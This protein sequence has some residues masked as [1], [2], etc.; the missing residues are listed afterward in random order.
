MSRYRA[1]VLGGDNQALLIVQM[2]PLILAIIPLFIFFRNLNM[3]N[4]FIPVIMVYT[5]T[6]LPFATWM[7][8]SSHSC[9]ST[10]RIGEV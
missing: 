3:V 10:Q 4:N 5:V 8:R 2:F 6:Q 1:R 9:N 7:L